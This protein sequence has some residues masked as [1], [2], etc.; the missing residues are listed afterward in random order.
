MPPATPALLVG[1][2]RQVMSKRAWP[3]TDGRPRVTNTSSGE[4]VPMIAFLPGDTSPAL[5]GSCTSAEAVSVTAVCPPPHAPPS[6]DPGS[7]CLGPVNSYKIA[8]W[9]RRFFVTPGD[10]VELRAISQAGEI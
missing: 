5:V 1:L 7:T 10:A 2:G 3:T 8:D 6:Q 4:V 9:L